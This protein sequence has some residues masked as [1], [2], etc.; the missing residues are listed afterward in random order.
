MRWYG[1]ALVGLFLAAVGYMLLTFPG[2]APSGVTY[3]SWT[4]VTG[5]GS[6]VVALL[7]LGRAAVARAR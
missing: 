6:L 2:M 1:H 3:G 7:L 5:I 4:E